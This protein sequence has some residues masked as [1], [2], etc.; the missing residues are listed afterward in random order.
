[1]I[2]VNASL[3]GAKRE[4]PQQVPGVGD[5]NGSWVK[6]S[7]FAKEIDRQIKEVREKSSKKELDE[8]YRQKYDLKQ[9]G[10]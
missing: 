7:E 9:L 1:M 4:S 10:G 2:A 5:N 6:A 8:L 3:K